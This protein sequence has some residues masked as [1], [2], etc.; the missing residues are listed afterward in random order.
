MIISKTPMRI[1]FLGGGTD[2]PAWFEQQDGAVLSSSID[3]YTYI[4]VRWLPPFFDHKY[5]IVWS[6]IENVNDIEEIYHPAVRECLRILDIHDGIV[7][8]HDGDLPARSGMGTSSTFTVGLLNALYAL[9]E[10]PIE[11][12]R[13]AEQAIYIEQNC[14]KDNV[15]NQDQIAAAIGGMN[16][17]EF[18]KSGF[19]WHPIHM[20]PERKVDLERHLM[21]VFTG[22]SRTASEV[23][24]TYRYPTEL[25]GMVDLVHEGAAV[26]Q[27]GRDLQEFG[28]LLNAGGELK[29]SMSPEICPPYISYLYERAI[30]AG[31]TGGKLLGAGSGGFMLLFCDPE[32]QQRVKDALKGLLLVPFHFEDKGTRIIVNGT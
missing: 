21:L 9:T 3:K 14:I 6:R 5:R 29:R 4:S 25:H 7:V 12:V 23:A 1:S 24:A 2:Y 15:G 30:A 19:L 11:S 18:R 20:S 26:L 32:K 16:L 28:K 27:S 31:A 17:I 8:N 13:L 22:L 10:Q